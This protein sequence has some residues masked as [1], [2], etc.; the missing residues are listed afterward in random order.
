MRILAVA[1]I[2]SGVSLVA[3]SDPAFDVASIKVNRS[4]AEG[5]GGGPRPGGRYRLTNMPARSLISAAWNIPA[6]RVLG[7]PGWIAV[8]RFDIDATMKETATFDETR[9]MLRTLLRT[10]FALTARVEQRDLRCT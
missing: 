1:L 7:G 9:G 2:V 3:Q 4:L 5:G 10:R 8:D 6:N